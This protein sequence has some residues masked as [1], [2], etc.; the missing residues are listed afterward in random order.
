MIIGTFFF[1]LLKYDPQTKR[2]T[3]LIKNL[4]FANG[5]EISNDESFLLVAE[6]GKYRVHK[7]V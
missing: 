1:R 2:N 7:Y 4:S 5:V 6:T 3:V